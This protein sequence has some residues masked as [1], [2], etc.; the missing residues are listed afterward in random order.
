[1]IK[2]IYVSLL[3]FT[4]LTFVTGSAFARGRRPQAW[5]DEF[6][7]SKSPTVVGTW[8]GTNTKTKLVFANDGTLTKFYDGKTGPASSKWHEA[9]DGKVYLLNPGAKQYICA[10]YVKDGTF[11]QDHGCYIIS[12]TKEKEE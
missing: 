10:G 7:E 5:K 1:M 9:T 4:L 6:K 8:V 11:H 3:T 12:F 2:C